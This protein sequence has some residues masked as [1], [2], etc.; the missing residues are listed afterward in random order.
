MLTCSCTLDIQL[1]DVEKE[2]KT[3]NHKLSKLVHWNTFSINVT[4]TCS[5]HS[6]Y[7]CHFSHFMTWPQ[8]TPQKCKSSI[9]GNSVWLSISSF[10]AEFVK[11]KNSLW[12]HTVNPSRPHSNIN[13]NK[14]VLLCSHTVYLI[15][16]ARQNW[17]SC[18]SFNKTIFEMK[19]VCLSAYLCMCAFCVSLCACVC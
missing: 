5:L 14:F 12:H 10:F 4:P 1:T 17:N 11:I 16:S 7:D 6:C 2:R 18:H 19:C 8:K 13:M 3:F 15:S 9:K